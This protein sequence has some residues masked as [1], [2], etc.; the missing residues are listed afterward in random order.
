ML[1]AV[2]SDN[3]IVLISFDKSNNRR[4]IIRYY[5]ITTVINDNHVVCEL[6]A[7]IT[8][9][10]KLLIDTGSGINLIKMNCLN[11]ELFV[12][13]NKKNIFEKNN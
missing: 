13:K 7:N 11:R 9:E 10:L 3:Y 6:S 1:R 8:N 2:N 4:Q 5:N 12:N